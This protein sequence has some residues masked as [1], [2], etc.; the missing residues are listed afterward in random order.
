MIP[1][2]SNLTDARIRN[3]RYLDANL[4]GING[5]TIPE[6]RAGS[7]TEVFHLYSILAENRDNL[8]IHLNTQGI[9]AKV[10]YYTP[11]HL[12]PAAKDFGYS[13]GM[14]PVAEMISQKTISLPVHE[15]VTMDELA[16]MVDSIKAFYR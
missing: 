7:N 5:I 2:L 4:K 15:F 14:F 1:K 12:Q 8:V 10:H 16:K 3:A 6:R 13:I 11:M 9:D